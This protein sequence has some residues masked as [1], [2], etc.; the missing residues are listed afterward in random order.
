MQDDQHNPDSIER[1]FQKKAGE[2]HI[3]F[4]EEDW[5]RLEKRLDLYELQRSY[6]RKFLLA[7]AAIIL[8]VSS[9]GY[10][11][12]DH[13]VR[14]NQLTD[15]IQGNQPIEIT[16]VEPPEQQVSDQNETLTLQSVDEV[17]PTDQEL[18]PT[19]NR[20][21]LLTKLDHSSETLQKLNRE[22]VLDQNRASDLLANL[23]HIPVS[24]SGF[25]HQVPVEFIEFRIL[26]PK[27]LF[28]R[29]DYFTYTDYNPSSR[30]DQESLHDDI[31]DEKRSKISLGVTYSPDYSR[32]DFSTAY[33]G[34]GYRFGL[35]GEYQITD[36][37][38][39]K[40]GV[41]LSKVHYSATGQQYNPPGYWN[42]GTQPSETNAICLIF[43][44][45]VGLKY[46]V[47]NFDQSRFFSTAALSS[48]IMLNEEYRFSYSSAY[49]G[50]QEQMKI[51]NGSRHFLNHLNLSI[52][53]EYDLTPAMSVRTE[54][55]IN[56][57][58]SGVGWGDVRFYSMGGFIS[59]NF[60][61]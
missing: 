57:P 40:T 22:F 46:N 33:T 1:L 55:F 29:P 54:P 30:P 3:P 23:Q 24:P 51:K 41:L 28:E 15:Q 48:Y 6:R 45:P 56:L 9:V 49:P 11:T 19:Q 35:K 59:L 42:Q 10:F 34:T 50:L 47:L 52:G 39:L 36:Q 18:E 20:L 38:F 37:L 17:N 31:P 61:M 5:N 32:P 44:I 2:Y 27:T 13:N 21:D 58:M 25:R 43:E 26:I 53:Y 8:I 14:L 12:Y 60:Q 7:V 16:P 4:R